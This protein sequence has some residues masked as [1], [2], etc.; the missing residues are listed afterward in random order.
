MNGS[1]TVAGAELAAAVKYTARWLTNRPVIPAHG[2][3]LFEVGGNSLHIFGFNE[4]VTARAS[5]ETDETELPRDR[6]VVAGRLMDQ[7]AATFPDKPIRFEREEKSVAVIAPRFRGS[8]PLMS[9]KDYPSLPGRGPLAGYVDGAALADAVGRVG[10]AANRDVTVNLPLCGVWINFDRLATE[11]DSCTLTLLTTDRYRAVMQVVPWLPDAGA[12][13]GGATLIYASA[14][15]DAVGAFAGHPKV[16]IGWEPGVFSLT[17]PARSL[18]VTGEFD[19]AKFPA[20]RLQAILK[21]APQVEASLSV[22]DIAVPLRQAD[23]FR[24]DQ[25][26]TV[27]LH[28]TADLVTVGA[29]AE[30][31]GAGDGEVDIAY[32]GP[33]VTLL[34]NSRYLHAALQSAPADRVSVGF[35]PGTKKPVFVTSPAAPSWRHMLQPLRA[36]T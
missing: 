16:E 25:S 32:D 8:L 22:K 3:L 13:L 26:E 9:E 33:E 24:A 34:L 12:R 7:L 23:L 18:V 1:F 19:K 2:G 14:L 36:L 21:T 35:T 11:S 28:F 31:R 15:T 5:V 20:E 10:V 27:R 17:T 30:G 29:D 4:N 6:F